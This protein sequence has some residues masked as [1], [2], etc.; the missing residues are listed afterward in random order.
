MIRTADAVRHRS[1]RGLNVART[2]PVLLYT[3]LSLPLPLLAQ[4]A[5]TPV[6][7]A[8]LQKLLDR[9]DQLEQKA[10]RVDVLEAELSSLKSGAVAAEPPPAAVMRDTFPKVQ[11]NLLG[12][13]TYHLSSDHSDKNTFGEGDID[14]IVTAKF[15]ENAGMLGDFVIAANHDGFGFEVERVLLQYTVNDYFNIEAGRYHTAIGYYN[16]TYH[17]GTYFQTTTERP[18]IYL[19]ED[20]E[21]ILPVH[22]VGI[23][24]NGDIPS[25]KWGLHY[26][27][28]IANGRDYSPGRNPFAIEDRN[29]AKAVNVALSAKPEW[30]PGVQIGASVYHDS[31]TPDGVA[32]TDQL[33]LSAYAVYKTPVFEWLNEGVFLRHAPNGDQAHWTSAAYTQ[34]SRRFGK[35]RPY[36]RLQWRNSP[37][38]DPVL[39]LIDQNTTL[40]GPTIGVRYDFTPMMAVKAEYEHTERRGEKSLDEM[41][42]QWTFRF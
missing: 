8:T 41:T 3:C 19:F 20:G 30:L 31:L 6:D 27:A 26:V 29:D 33:I 17:N 25:G 14:P 21:G 37:E 16:N 35:V 5:A 9:I 1:L 2:L 15:S 32:R 4:S 11:F 24:V 28:E 18:S 36:V 34:V 22:S 12:D 40:W 39:A 42:L 13:V 23:S 38:A 10:K 7:Q